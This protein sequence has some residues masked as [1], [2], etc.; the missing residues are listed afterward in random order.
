[1]DGPGLLLLFLLLAGS[2]ALI[3]KI[4]YDKTRIQEKPQESQYRDSAATIS[5]AERSTKLLS[6]AILTKTNKLDDEITSHRVTLVASYGSAREAFLGVVEVLDGHHNGQAATGHPRKAKLLKSWQF[7]GRG[8]VSDAH[9]RSI[10]FA[11]L[12]YQFNTGLKEILS[13]FRVDG[14]KVEQSSTGSDGDVY[15]MSRSQ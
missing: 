15:H 4:R 9:R 3:A 2:V 11:H 7:A 13:D 1:M 5:S 14:W 10:D 8:D 6:A 12:K